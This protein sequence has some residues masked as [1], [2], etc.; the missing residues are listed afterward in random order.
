MT[1]EKQVDEYMKFAR[2][3][4]TQSLILFIT[5]A[6]ILILFPT[7]SFSQVVQVVYKASIKKIAYQI[8]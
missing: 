6:S 2:F 3:Q 8:E 1:K 7:E 4:D 5:L